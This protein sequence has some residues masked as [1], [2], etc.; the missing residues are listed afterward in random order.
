[1]ANDDISARDPDPLAEQLQRDAADGAD[2]LGLT[3]VGFLADSD[4]PGYRR[5]FFT[6]GAYVEF[7]VEDVVTHAD[8]PAK[9][10]PVLGE[11]ATSVRLSPDAPVEYVRSESTDEFDLNLRL[12]K[13]PTTFLVV[14]W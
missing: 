11:R 6:S 14:L 1:M 7:Q 8:V 9:Q 12:H 2:R 10:S 5:L 3:F 4:K 13:I